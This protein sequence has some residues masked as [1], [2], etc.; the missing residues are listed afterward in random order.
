MRRC[1]REFALEIVTAATDGDESRRPSEPTLTD[2]RPPPSSSSTQRRRRRSTGTR[3]Q[4]MMS[5]VSGQRSSATPTSA[6]DVA[7]SAG[8]SSRPPIDPAAA[9][10]DRH[11]P[12]PSKCYR[13]ALSVY[14]DQIV[15][16]NST[17]VSAAAA[18]AAAA[19]ELS[20]SSA[21]DS[22]IDVNSSASFDEVDRRRPPSASGRGRS[23]SISTTFQFATGHSAPLSVKQFT[24]DQPIEQPKPELDSKSKRD[25]KSRSQ[26]PATLWRSI[27][28]SSLIRTLSRRRASS[29]SRNDV[30]P[31]V[32]ADETAA[33][34]SK[35]SSLDTDSD[36]EN[37]DAATGQARRRRVRGGSSSGSAGSVTGLG[38]EAGDPRRRCETIAAGSGE[39]RRRRSGIFGGTRSFRRAQTTA[40]ADDDTVGSQSATLPRRGKCN[41]GRGGE[42]LRSDSPGA[43][44]LSSRTSSWA[45]LRRSHTS[46]SLSLMKTQMF[47]LSNGFNLVSA[48]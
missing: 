16:G 31:A 1:G 4:L 19:A 30:A 39:T 17:L 37:R 36:C 24:D 18:A 9:V 5:C 33:S 26:S 8:C 35:L 22:G 40:A 32:T 20:A 15:R 46:E 47:H 21:G 27:S 6:V 13:P 3:Q 7:N 45:S 12:R 41:D 48:S 38:F 44:R 10:R 2:Q 28:S 43:S 34:R 11:S 25:R 42:L 29:K 23:R 14:G